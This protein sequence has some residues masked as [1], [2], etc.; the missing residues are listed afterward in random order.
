MDQQRLITDF[1][2]RT[3]CY[4][5]L[6]LLAA[7]ITPSISVKEAFVVSVL[8]STLVTATDYFFKEEENLYL[9]IMARTVTLALSTFAIASTDINLKDYHFQIG[10]NKALQL[11]F[12][13]ALGEVIRI[14]IAQ[15]Y[16]EPLPPIMGC[17]D[18]VRKVIETTP[19]FTGYRLEGQKTCSVMEPTI[20]PANLFFEALGLKTIMPGKGLFAFLDS[21][22]AIRKGVYSHSKEEVI[23]ITAMGKECQL[24]GQT[25]A[26]DAC[27]GTG[28]YALSYEEIQQMLE[29]QKIYLSPLIPKAFYLG[30]KEAMGQDALVEIPSKTL[31]ELSAHASPNL[32]RFLNA[33]SADPLSFGFTSSSQYEQFSSLTLYQLGAMVVKTEDYYC[34]TGDG[35]QIADR[36]VGDKDQLLLINACGIRGFHTTQHIAGNENHEIDRTIMKETFKI[37]MESIGDGG[38]YTLPALGMGVWGG[39]PDVYWG[40]FFDAVLETKVN[41]ENIIVC[42]GHQKTPGTNFIGQEFGEMLAQYKKAHPN[43][44]KLERIVNLFHYKTDVVLV[45][46]HLKAQFPDRVV[47]LQN[48]SDPD[49]TLGYHVGEYV[50]N[51]SHPS[52]T[53]ENYSAIG[54]NC[55]N[56]ER[57]TG[58]LNNSLR[59]IQHDA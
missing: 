16:K 57:H 28:V 41:L 46:K 22:E 40:A 58:V 51:L 23:H 25:V 31:K 47:A 35:Y 13:S 9:N 27:Y 44:P 48:A 14:S 24:R 59:I 2:T 49:V 12:Y 18:E 52:T 6:S 32:M 53:E 4:G 11:G 56:F 29:S 17:S 19:Q 42:P 54:S 10:Q 20:R 38:F 33:V 7:K 34:F 36:N 30:L 21:P 15:F 8:N 3:L 26:M 1:S 5:V 55:L 50:N 45:A 39:T 37:A 43:H